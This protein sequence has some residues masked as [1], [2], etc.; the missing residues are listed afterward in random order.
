[1]CG[2]PRLNVTGCFVLGCHYRSL[3]EEF[4]PHSTRSPRRCESCRDAIPSTQNHSGHAASPRALDAAWWIGPRAGCRLFAIYILEDIQNSTP[5]SQDFQHGLGHGPNDSY[6]DSWG[7]SK[8]C[9]E[10]TTWGC[11]TDCCSGPRYKRRCQL[12]LSKAILLFQ[13][14]FHWWPYGSEVEQSPPQL[15]TS[16]SDV[17]LPWQTIQGHARPPEIHASQDLG[18]S[19]WMLSTRYIC[20]WWLPTISYWH[21][22]FERGCW[23]AFENWSVESFIQKRWTCEPNTL[24]PSVRCWC[25]WHSFWKFSFRCWME[26]YDWENCSM[27]IGATLCTDSVWALGQRIV[28]EVF[29]LWSFSCF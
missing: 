10:A 4:S 17:L 16:L 27:V 22:W 1:M 24:L 2:V 14:L 21:H 18:G 5:N 12:S 25:T 9:Q 28:G 29:P 20:R 26:E 15:P 7:W 19:F 23:V 3:S 6:D 11:F 13:R 8:D